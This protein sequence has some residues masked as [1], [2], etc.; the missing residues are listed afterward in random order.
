MGVLI[1]A[2][3]LIEHERGRVNVEPHLEGREQEGFFL[4]VITA[5]YSTAYTAPRIQTFA[6]GALHSWKQC[7]SDSPC[8]RWI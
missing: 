8:C 5:S 4:S 1:D 3:V 7:W 6:R 2:S